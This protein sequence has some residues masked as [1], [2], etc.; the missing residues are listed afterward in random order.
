MGQ[1]FSYKAYCG[2]VCAGIIFQIFIKLLGEHLDTL[3]KEKGMTG[4][5]RLLLAGSVI[6]DLDFIR[7]IEELDS[8]IVADSLC[9][10]SKCYTDQVSLNVDP[11]AAI[12]DRYL[13]HTCCPRMYG[14]YRE[15][16][17]FIKNKVQKA[18]VDG[19]ILQN[20]RFCDMHGADNGLMARDLEAEGIPVLTLEREYG[21]LV[22]KGRI[23]MR[24]EAFLERI[25]QRE[26]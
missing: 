25:H 14:R 5:K 1:P 13:N 10:G 23:R 24:V 21:P 22:E 9:F 19:I 6:D 16:L 4:K 18:K 20:I 17:A 2:L 15:R 8:V 12:S 11:M 3:E 7:L 26:G